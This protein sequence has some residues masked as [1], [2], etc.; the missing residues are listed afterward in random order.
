MRVK[1]TSDKQKQKDSDWLC[2]DA[3][4]LN[5]K[6]NGDICEEAK[7]IYVEAYLEYVR[8]GMRPEEA[9]Q[10]AKSV[11]KCFLATHDPNYFP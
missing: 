3:K 4:A 10:K 9:V 1:L 7:K 6:D 2:D 8:E 11:A 5:K